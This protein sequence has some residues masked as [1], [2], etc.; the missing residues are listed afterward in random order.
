MDYPAH[1]VV[2]LLIT[3]CL[4]VPLPVLVAKSRYK[5][6]H[7]LSA[8]KSMLVIIINNL[9]AFS[10]LNYIIIV[11][12]IFEPTGSIAI[13]FWGIL[14]H[15]YIVKR[16]CA[17]TCGGLPEINPDCRQQMANNL[18]SN[19]VGGSVSVP[20]FENVQQNVA[21]QEQTKVSRV[22]V[23]KVFIKKTGATE[24]N[25]VVHDKKPLRVKPI[26]AVLAICFIASVAA[27]IYQCFFVNLKLERE[28]ATTQESLSK[29]SE[30]KDAYLDSNNKIYAENSLLKQ[31]NNDLSLQQALGN[32]E[33]E[34]Y[35][36]HIAVTTSPNG[37]CAYHTIGCSYLGDTV[38]VCTIE[39]A[40]S[41]GCWPCSKCHR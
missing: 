29:T 41:R 2:S 21:A 28:L 36:N 30:L 3:F 12:D 24:K 38:Y 22:A 10:M 34:W 11:F 16:Y 31:E 1:L 8:G 40:E 27:N 23:K 37:N 14:T 33:L 15:Q 39:N 26:V 19:I 25:P 13:F 18:N 20:K 9:I 4:Y 32:N 17:P 7:P 5:S 35:R 6:G